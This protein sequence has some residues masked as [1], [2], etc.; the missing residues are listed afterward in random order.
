MLT[1]Q[2]V[3]DFPRISLQSLPHIQLLSDII[4]GD[5]VVHILPSPGEAGNQLSEEDTT[6]GNQ[7]AEEC[8]CCLMELS[9]PIGRPDTCPLHKCHLQCLIAWTETP[10]NRYRPLY[11]PYCRQQFTSIKKT[12][13]SGEAEED[14]QPR[15][16]Y[17]VVGGIDWEP[18]RRDI[19]IREEQ[20]R[21]LYHPGWR[22]DEA[23][24]QALRE[25]R[26]RGYPG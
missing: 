2:V 11:C 17:V 15:E 20:Q 26:R 25:E 18:I 12:S 4:E 23:F 19:R 10:L 8:F 3:I 16:T 5:T 7:L 22:T 6:A 24:L 21:D 1:N 13:T 14:F 9:H